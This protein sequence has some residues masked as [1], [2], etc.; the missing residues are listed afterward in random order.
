MKYFPILVY[1]ICLKFTSLVNFPGP[2]KETAAII[3]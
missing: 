2:A 3:K 1:K